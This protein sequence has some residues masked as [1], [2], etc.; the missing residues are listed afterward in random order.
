M[1]HDLFTD[2]FSVDPVPPHSAPAALA[3]RMS[4]LVTTRHGDGTRTLAHGAA[5][6]IGHYERTP[7][8]WRGVTQGGLMVRARTEPG[9]RRALVE[10]AI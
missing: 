6:T 2:G 9:V 3:P 4:G 7:D 1:T 10:A 5:G 8:G